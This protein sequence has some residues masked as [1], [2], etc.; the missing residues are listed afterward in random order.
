M[1]N[2]HRVLFRQAQKILLCPAGGD[3]AAAAAALQCIPLL[4][5]ASSSHPQFAGKAPPPQSLQMFLTSAQCG[6]NNWL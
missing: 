4:K 1:K 5:G 2:T 3:G 6:I